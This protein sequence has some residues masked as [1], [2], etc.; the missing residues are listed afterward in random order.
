MKCPIHP[1][2]E[3]TQ[4]DG[5]YGPFWSH[6]LADGTWC[7]GK[8][9]RQAP[10]AYA[11]TA[12]TPAVHL[13]DDEPPFTDDEPQT[14]ARFSRASEGPDWEHIGRVKAL[15]GMV[16]AMLQTRESGIVRSQIPML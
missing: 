4:K 7:N 16:N 9:K 12:P 13:P 1:N 8:P 11:A 3:M 2:E 6:R 5:Q 15:C 14:E 10:G